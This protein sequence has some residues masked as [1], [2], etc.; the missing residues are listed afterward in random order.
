VAFD[1][2]IADEFRYFN[3]R[4]ATRPSPPAAKLPPR[5]REA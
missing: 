1:L 4:A 2:L 5:L 3:T